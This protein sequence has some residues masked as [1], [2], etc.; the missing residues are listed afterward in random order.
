MGFSIK[1]VEQ[2]LSLWSD[3]QRESRDVRALAQAHMAES[4]AK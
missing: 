4:T 2:L 3:T 1:Q